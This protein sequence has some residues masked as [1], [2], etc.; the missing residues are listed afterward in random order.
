[1]PLGDKEKGEEWE[2]GIYF[3]KK[4]GQKWP[5]FEESK[6]E[7]TIFRQQVP[8]THSRDPKFF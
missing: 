2:Q 6:T 5:Y 8:P 7:N 3:S 4:N 1:L